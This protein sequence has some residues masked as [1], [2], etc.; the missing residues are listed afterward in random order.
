MWLAFSY[1]FHLVALLGGP[2]SR[3]RR[4]RKS[5]MSLLVCAVLLEMRRAVP[6]VEMGECWSVGSL[7]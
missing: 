6:D 2:V 4:V 1:W 7:G 5:M 3:W